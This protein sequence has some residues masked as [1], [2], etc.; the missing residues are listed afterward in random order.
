MHM[1]GP[2]GPLPLKQ[3]NHL[4]ESETIEYSDIS[5]CLSHPI[6]SFSTP[7]SA[8][9]TEHPATRV[10]AGASSRGSIY[11]EAPRLLRFC[12]SMACTIAS[13]AFG[14]LR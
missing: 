6:V 10:C 2:A 14:V 1:V 8:A 9:Q 5:G 7:S 3:N 13:L 4:A 12:H 11:P